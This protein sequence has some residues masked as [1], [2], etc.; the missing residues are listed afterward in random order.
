MY[1][2]NCIYKG[3]QTYAVK[4]TSN[5]YQGLKHTFLAGKLSAITL[6]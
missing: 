1:L 3:F 2:E 4:I 5:P 6:S